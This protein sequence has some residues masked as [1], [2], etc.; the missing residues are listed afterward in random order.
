MLAKILSRDIPDNLEEL[1]LIEIKTIP[2]ITSRICEILAQG[3]HLRI[4]YLVQA[5]IETKKCVSE[6]C[7]FITNND[8]LIELDISNNRMPPALMAKV[9]KV[10]SHNR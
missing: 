5:G 8:N 6:L 7:Q 10:L 3:C 9:L 2:D 4:L 1:R